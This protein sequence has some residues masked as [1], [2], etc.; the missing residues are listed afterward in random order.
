MVVFGA[1]ALGSAVIQYLS[2]AGVGT[3]KVVDHETVALENLQSQ[4][5]HSSRDIKRPKVA[6]ARDFV[7]NILRN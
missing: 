6:S 1:G 2:A 4:V 3:I 5:I 7:R